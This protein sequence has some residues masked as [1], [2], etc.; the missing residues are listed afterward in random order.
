MSC[1]FKFSM[2]CVSWQ[3]TTPKEYYVWSS[4]A[5]PRLRMM[6][7]L[8]W[9]KNKM[10][11]LAIMGGMSLPRNHLETSKFVIWGVIMQMFDKNTNMFD[12]MSQWAVIWR[13][14]G[15]SNVMLENQ[16]WPNPEFL[17]RTTCFCYIFLFKF[18]AYIHL[19]LDVLL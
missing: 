9:K 5:F 7:M 17:Q 4:V 10:K 3:H 12:E 14:N 15:G 2:V 16:I 18:K 1:S 11:P 13:E 19:W 6:V 8:I